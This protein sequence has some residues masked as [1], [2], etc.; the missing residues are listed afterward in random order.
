VF[1]DF[2]K[3]VGTKRKRRKR[4]TIAVTEAELEDILK[5]KKGQA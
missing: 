2:V 4:E 5:E 1:V 3:F